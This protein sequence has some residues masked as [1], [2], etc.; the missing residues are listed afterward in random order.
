MIGRGIEI[1]SADEVNI[2]EAELQYELMEN[3][4][5]VL[6]PLLENYSGICGIEWYVASMFHL[7]SRW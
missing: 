6:L 7:Q 3:K 1:A 5:Y 2:A 4:S